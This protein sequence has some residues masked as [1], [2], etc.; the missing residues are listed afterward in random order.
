VACDVT[1]VPALRH[2][3]V[4]AKKSDAE[5][6]TTGVAI[7]DGCGAELEDVV[8]TGASGIG[9]FV[10]AGAGAPTTAVVDSTFEGNGTGIVLRSG[11]FSLDSSR[12]QANVKRGLWAKRRDDGENPPAITLAIS[13]T[14]FTA[15]GDT[16]LKLEDLPSGSSVTLTGLQIHGNRATTDDSRH[17]GTR[18]AGGLVLWGPP[19][20]PFAMKGSRIYGN[21]CDQVGIYSS[22]PWN[23]SGL[24]TPPADACATPNVFACPAATFKLVY[25]SGVVLGPSEDATRNVWELDPPTNDLVNTNYGPTCPDS[26]PSLLPDCAR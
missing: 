7:Y 20:V 19:P 21:H 12:I 15:N 1:A 5:A 6:F 4:L 16:G 14:T 9:L 22:T 10:D 26:V 17:S 2:V 11:K 8:V 3:H 13:G 18:L 24:A 23:L 25:F